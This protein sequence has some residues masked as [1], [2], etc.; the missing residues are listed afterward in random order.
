MATVRARTA[1]DGTRSWAVLYRADGRQ[2]S[3]T[4]DDPHLAELFRLH[5]EAGG[6]QAALTWIAQYAP[7]EPGVEPYTVRE[8]AE[9]YLAWKTPRVRSDRTIADYRRDV[10]NRI[11]PTFGGLPGAA[12]TDTQVQDWIDAMTGALSPKTIA[13]YHALLSGMFGW[14]SSSRG[15][16]VVPS[17]PCLNTDL[18][19]R[20]KQ[21]ARGLRPSEWAILH[22]AATELYPDAADLLLFLVGS[23]W[24]WS[25]ATALQVSQIDD[26]GE[27]LIVDMDAVMRRRADGKVMRVSDAKSRAGTRSVRLSPL[28]AQMVRRRVIGKR[29]GDRVFTNPSAGEWH[30]S[31]FLNRY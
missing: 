23:G 30:Y 29:L 8:L 5:F 19:R 17:N 13:G 16:R 7:P 2:T 6:L 25:E 22:Q 12:V 24:R 3:T 15:G 14:G 26:D 27:R 11:L 1:K 9:A 28:V 18:P 4:F 31:N 21:R 10:S 20:T